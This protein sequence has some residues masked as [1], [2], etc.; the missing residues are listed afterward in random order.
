MISVQNLLRLLSGSKTIFLVILVA[1]SM[2]SCSVFEDIFG[3]GKKPTPPPPIEETEKPDDEVEE[4][5]EEP[6][7][8]VIDTTKKTDPIDIRKQVNIAVILPFQL[9]ELDGSTTFSSVSKNSLE[10]YKGIKLSLEEM[11][12]KDFDFNVYVFDNKKDP[13]ITKSI[14]EE[15]P[16]PNV[17]AVIG[18]LYTENLRVVS[19]YAKENKI[20][21]I[22]PLSS[23]TS[24]AKDNDFI[25]SANATKQ[26]R[27]RILLEYIKD[28]F[29]DANIGIIY[30]TDRSEEEAKDEILEIAA[31]ENIDIQV[32]KSEGMS[33]F[34]VSEQL[35]ETGRDNVIILP[36]DDDAEGIRHLD[37]LMSYLQP[38]GTRYNINVIGLS[39]WN[40]ISQ[41]APAKYP[42]VNFY[43][44]DRFFVDESKFSL[45]NKVEDL[46]TQN[47]GFPLHIYALQGYDL[48]NYIGE[49]AK[50]HGDK[51]SSRVQKEQYEGLQTKYEFD[52]YTV[53]GDDL[54]LENKHINILRFRNGRWEKVN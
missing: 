11:K 9:D 39:E 19:E 8:E 40:G 15:A 43:I 50:K 12:F 28:N 14:L 17:Q 32:K 29:I 51:L 25:L 30:R 37:G 10:I 35:L 6:D 45:R 36:T 34:T 23:S 16:F 42:S 27:Y 54:F 52:K 31:Q 48:M 21:F 7:V 22:S 2:Q 13:Q 38:F 18:P 5:D 24:L 47:G 3:G 53:G 46:K 26:T 49:L 20:P 4:P 41:I 33:M 44:L 1:L